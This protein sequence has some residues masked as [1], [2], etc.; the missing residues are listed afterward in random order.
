MNFDVEKLIRMNIAKLSNPQLLYFQ[1]SIHKEIYRRL[2]PE[3]AASMDAQE[4]ELVN[5]I[6]SKKEGQK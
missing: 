5:A 3:H 2:E 6:M 4:E 1:H